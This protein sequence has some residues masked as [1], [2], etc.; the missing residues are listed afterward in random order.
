MKHANLGRN[1]LRALTLGV[2]LVALGYDVARNGV[3]VFFEIAVRGAALLFCL[4][5][6]GLRVVSK[7]G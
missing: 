2:V 1:V 6:L 7:E 3:G 5:L 4:W